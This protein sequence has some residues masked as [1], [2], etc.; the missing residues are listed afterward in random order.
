MD[1]LKLHQKE[2]VSWMVNAESRDDALFHGEVAPNGGILADEVGLGKTIQT[3]GLLL[4]APKKSLIIVPKSLIHQW[5]DE[6]T[7][8]APHMKLVHLTHPIQLTSLSSEDSY[9]ISSSYFNRSTSVIGSSP[10]HKT[11]WGRI[12][13]DEAHAIKNKKS[14][15]HKTLDCITSDARWCLTATPVMNKMDDFISL[16]GF[17]GVSKYVCQGFK[18]DVVRMFI[19]RRTK[20]DVKH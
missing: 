9:I 10:I 6:C 3:I 7:R 12:I 15:L 4:S 13:I 16:L 2:G 11:H 14:K 8:F 20:D 1:Y 18:D 17:I 19:K 5:I